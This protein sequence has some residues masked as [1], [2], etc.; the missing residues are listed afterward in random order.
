M[1]EFIFGRNDHCKTV[2]DA[3]ARQIAAQELAEI[4]RAADAEVKAVMRRI[5]AAGGMPAVNIALA[6]LDDP[7]ISLDEIEVAAV[8]AGKVVASEQA[9]ALPQRRPGSF[10]ALPAPRAA[11]PEAESEWLKQA[12]LAAE[13]EWAKLFPQSAPLRNPQTLSGEDLAFAMAAAGLAVGATSARRDEDGRVKF[14][15]DHIDADLYAKG[16]AAA[17]RLWPGI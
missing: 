9:R 11:M 8:K 1:T 3:R 13:S 6:L 10:A 4:K 12:R 16:A 5:S 15:G 14:R 17:R 2:T 7:S